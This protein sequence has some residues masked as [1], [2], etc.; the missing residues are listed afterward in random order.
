M[1]GKP[2]LR[3]EDFMEI[4]MPSGLMRINAPFA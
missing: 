1:E 4:E 3:L 2:A